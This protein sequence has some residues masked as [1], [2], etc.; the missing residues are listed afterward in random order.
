MFLGIFVLS[1][2]TVFDEQ[3]VFRG[4]RAS[5]ADWRHHVDVSE[6][7]QRRVVP[8]YHP[9]AVHTSLFDYMLK[10]N[11]LENILRTIHLMRSQKHI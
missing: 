2:H 4:R 10:K 6:C 5:R 1:T 3:V 8:K 9:L 11:M 7:G